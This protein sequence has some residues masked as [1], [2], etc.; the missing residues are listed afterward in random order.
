MD[1]KMDATA[2]ATTIRLHIEQ[3]VLEGFAPGDSRGLAAAVEAELARLLAEQGVPPGL[4]A[5]GRIPSLDG[6][7]FPVTVG[8]RPQQVGVQVARAVLG[9]MGR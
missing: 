1:V 7:S 2:G 3:L 4:A 6:G 5:G 8:A 9:G